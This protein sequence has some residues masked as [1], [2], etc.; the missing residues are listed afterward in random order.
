M[1]QAT[2]QQNVI[3]LSDLLKDYAAYNLWA[4]KRLVDWL[5]TKPASVL[6]I[7]VLSSFPSIKQTLFHIWNVQEWWLGI[8]EGSQPESKYWQVFEGSADEIFEGILQQSE[9]F[10]AYAQA[11]T[12]SSI[13]KN[14][15]FSIPTVGEFTRQRF[16][17]IQHTMNHSTYHR[18]QIVTIG[19]NLGLTDAP[20]TDYM[21]YLLM[22]K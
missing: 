4:N 18:G 10:A 17:I 12:E 19:R 11:L 16:E 3:S 9:E 22:A 2:T 15:P 14:C 1:Q 5:R 21:F 13:F 7:E 8:L 20:M 6:D